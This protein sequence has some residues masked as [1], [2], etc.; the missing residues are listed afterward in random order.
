MGRGVVGVVMAALPF[1]GVVARGRRAASG[2][3][4]AA[5]SAVAFAVCFVVD[6]AVFRWVLQG[7]LPGVEHLAALSFVAASATTAVAAVCVLAAGE[8]SA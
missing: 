7:A 6:G 8:I 2:G 1:F 3:A 5:L 4:R